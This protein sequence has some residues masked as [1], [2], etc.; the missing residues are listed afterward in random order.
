M[1]FSRTD[2]P[3]GL[4]SAQPA[5]LNPSFSILLQQDDNKCRCSIPATAIVLV[6]GFVLVLVLV[7]G[8][9]FHW[10]SR[11]LMLAGD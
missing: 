11:R 6:L 10:V 8:F 7:L 4:L 1:S 2:S 5:W 9:S 3:L